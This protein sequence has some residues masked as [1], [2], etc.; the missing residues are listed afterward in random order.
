MGWR[1]RRSV[2]VLPG[3]RLNVSKSGISTSIGGPGATL[4][5]GPKGT[6]QT[7]GLPGS[8]VSYSTFTPKG[9]GHAQGPGSGKG[10][11]LGGC[12]VISIALVLL[13]MIGRCVGGGALPEPDAFGSAASEAAFADPIG[14]ATNFADGD[15]V[16]IATAAL[17]TR[18]EP[19]STGTV[20]GTLHRGKT[21]KVLRRSGEWLQVAQ[22]AAL[23]WIAASHVKAH[24]S[25]RQGFSSTQA[26][27]RHHG[28]A[29]SHKRRSSGS[30]GF[31]EGCPCGGSRVCVGPRGGRYCITSGGNKRYGV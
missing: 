12:A 7:V 1:F 3:V 13:V 24:A 31:D 4:N 29:K 20:V 2:K 5:I 26:P 19:S 8:G 30:S 18:S 14:A 16:A 9:Q 22:G 15:E 28:G 23:V 11:G 25:E 27:N 17:R 10:S 21:V 6:R